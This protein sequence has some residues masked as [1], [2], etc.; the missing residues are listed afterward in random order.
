MWSIFIKDNQTKHTASKI[1][2]SAGQK[3]LWIWQQKTI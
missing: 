1:K 2:A 3:H